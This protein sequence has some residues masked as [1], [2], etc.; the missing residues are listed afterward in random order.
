MITRLLHPFPLQ[1][2]Q[3]YT[4]SYAEKIHQYDRA[5]CT[6]KSHVLYLSSHCTAHAP[7]TA[8][9]QTDHLLRKHVEKNPQQLPER[10]SHPVWTISGRTATSEQT[11]QCAQQL[12]HSDRNSNALTPRQ[13]SLPHAPR[14]REALASLPP[15]HLLCGAPRCPEQA[16]RTA[17]ATVSGTSGFGFWNRMGVHPPGYTPSTRVPTQKG[18]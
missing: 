10:R 8:G 14:V 15:P 12:D 13:R 4:K 3:L 5:P 16:S 9:P 11:A 2:P 6:L 17:W 1:S 7:Y 18:T